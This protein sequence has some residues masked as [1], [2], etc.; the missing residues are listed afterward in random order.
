MDQEHCVLR[1]Q[2]CRGF[3]TRKYVVWVLI[4]FGIYSGYKG[5]SVS[6]VKSEMKN[7]VESVLEDVSHGTTDKSIRTR[8]LRRTASASL[9]VSEGNI[10]IRRESRTGERILH[11][12]VEYPVTINYLGSERTLESDLHVT[13]VV[14]VNEAAE[15]RRAEKLRREEE[16]RQN[17]QAFARE[18]SR[19]LEPLWNECEAKHGKGNCRLEAWPGKGPGEIVKMY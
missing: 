10:T 7:A 14:K 19:K 3:V 17:Y 6:L 11:I 13:K 1:N 5:L 8:L 16:R 9:P 2:N 15:A 4:L 18:H 12:D